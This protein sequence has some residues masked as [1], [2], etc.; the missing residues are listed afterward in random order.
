VK[1][2]PIG[3]IV[4][5][6][7]GGLLVIGAVALFFVLRRRPKSEPSTATEFP[8][9]TPADFGLPEKVEPDPPRPEE[10]VADEPY[11]GSHLK[12]PTRKEA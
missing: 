2:K 10:Q 1:P 12:F 6:V 4:G 11:V 9:Y 8:H 3:G 7:V 5:G